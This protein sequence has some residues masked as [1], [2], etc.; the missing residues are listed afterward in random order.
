MCGG[1]QLDEDEMDAR[2]LVILARWPSGDPPEW[3]VMWSAGTPDE[4]DLAESD[5]QILQELEASAKA[6]EKGLVQLRDEKE[7]A[8]G[9]VAAVANPWQLSPRFD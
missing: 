5:R 8:L 3:A 1:W 4:E 2:Y 6:I 9:P 7:K